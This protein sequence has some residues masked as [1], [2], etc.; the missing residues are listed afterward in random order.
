MKPVGKGKP[1]N[2][3][4]K[5][6]VLNILYSNSKILPTDQDIKITDPNAGVGVY[7]LDFLDKFKIEK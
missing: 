5:K 7:S 4:N 2:L 6:E 3:K 1:I